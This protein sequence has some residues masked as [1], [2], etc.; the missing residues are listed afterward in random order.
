MSL[1]TFLYSFLSSLSFWTASFLGGAISLSSQFILIL[2]FLSNS[3]LATPLAFSSE[4]GFSFFCDI[5][6]LGT[7]WI[8]PFSFLFAEYFHHQVISLFLH[9]TINS[10]DQNVPQVIF[11][12]PECLILLLAKFTFHKKTGTEIQFIQFYYYFTTEITF[13]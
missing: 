2:I 11:Y 3:Y 7:F 4:H 9:F 12:S 1:V 6:R 8:F 13:V 5:D 10:Q